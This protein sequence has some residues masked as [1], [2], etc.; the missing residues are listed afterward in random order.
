MGVQFTICPGQWNV[1]VLIFFCLDGARFDFKNN[2]KS[3]SIVCIVKRYSVFQQEL[4]HKQAVQV[5]GQIL[6]S[7]VDGIKTPERSRS[8]I[9]AY[10]TETEVF[11]RKN[12]G[13]RFS[14]F[15]SNFNSLCENAM[16][17]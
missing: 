15:F 3:F 4:A 1:C 5:I 10:V 12:K 13:V 11:E 17:S 16:I 8:P 6:D 2:Y 7:L 14:Q 9:D